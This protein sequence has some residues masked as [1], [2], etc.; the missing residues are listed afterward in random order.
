MN[1]TKYWRSTQV[2]SRDSK[3]NLNK[4]LVIDSDPETARVLLGIFAQKGIHASVATDKD[5][6]AKYLQN[7]RWNIVFINEKIDA[8]PKSSKMLAKA[9]SQNPE[10]PVVMLSDTD[11]A[12]VA[13]SAIKKGYADCLA[14]PIDAELVE[15]IVDTYCPN[16][17]VRVLAKLLAEPNGT[18]NIIG[19]SYELLRTV[20]LAKKAAPT[21]APALITGQSGTGK[22][23][24]AQLI[25]EN[26]KRADK[27]FIKINC[28]ALNDSLLESELFGHEKGAFTGALAL[29]KGKFERANGGTI[30]LDEITETPPSFQAKLLRVLEEMDFERVGG[31]ENININVR[32]ISTTNKNMAEEIKKGNFR[33]D[34]Y[35]RLSGVKLFVPP[36]QNRKADL[37]P[38]TWHFVNTFGH[39][40]ARTITA[41]D[42]ATLKMFEEYHWPGNIRQLR[43]IVRNAIIFGSGETLSLVET[44]WLVDEIRATE[45][46]DS[47]DFTQLANATLQELEQKAIFATLDR[48]EGNK[49]KAAKVLGIS[50]RTLR[51]KIKRYNATDRFQL[52]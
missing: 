35:Y 18:N 38:L 21:S 12:R 45:I 36:L 26:S 51:D 40:T 41:I 25:H 42:S 16:N 4:A 49:T 17:K 6:A 15:T 20:E 52:A 1:R 14:K 37:V 22:E 30:L 23:L 50:D 43:N 28:A 19:T 34:L 44:P 29:H 5:S 31:S 11:N 2:T 8:S 13:I 46:P 39:E 24:I 47:F 33:E 9:K 48:T 7:N 3:T 32:I 27:P 10:L